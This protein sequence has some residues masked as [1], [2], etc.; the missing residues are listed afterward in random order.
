MHNTTHHKALKCTVQYSTV[1]HC[2][3]LY[4]AELHCAVQHTIA[5]CCTILCS[6]ALIVATR[7]CVAVNCTVW[8]RLQHHQQ[9]LQTLPAIIQHCQHGHSHVRHNEIQYR[10][11][12]AQN[13][14]VLWS[15]YCT[16]LCCTAQYRADRSAVLYCA[17]CAVM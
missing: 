13:C 4:C 9:R 10:T 15:T 1:L 8:D 5:L 14:T 2:T 11:L 16:V 17:V 12:G 6:T 3:A 7:C